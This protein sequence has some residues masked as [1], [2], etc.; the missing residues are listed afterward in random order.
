MSFLWVKFKSSNAIEVPFA[1]GD[2]VC[3]LRKA[4]KDAFSPDVD[5]FDAAQ[6][7]LSLTDC[8]PI[9]RL[10]LKIDEIP[11]QDGYI[12]NDHENPLFLYVHTSNLGDWNIY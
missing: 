8:G 9:L 12:K 1:V 11:Y 3:D 2:I 7:S 4:C 5:G 6:L 10:N